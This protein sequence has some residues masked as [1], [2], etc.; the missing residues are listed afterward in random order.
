MCSVDAASSV[1]S[2]CAEVLLQMPRHAR[3][4]YWLMLV[5]FKP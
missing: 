1:V 3:E 5:W 2:A 4:V